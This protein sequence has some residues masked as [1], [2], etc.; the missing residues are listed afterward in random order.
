MSGWFSIKFNNAFIFPDPEPPIINIL[1]GWSGIYGQ[2]LFCWVL[3]SLT[4][5]NLSFILCNVFYLAFNFHTLQKH[6]FHMDML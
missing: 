6:L 2:F 5:Q 1:Y 3:F 4:Y